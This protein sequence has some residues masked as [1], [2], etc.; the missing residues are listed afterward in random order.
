[1]SGKRLTVLAAIVVALSLSVTV[2]CPVASIAKPAAAK[3]AVKAPAKAPTKAPIDVMATAGPTAVVAVVNG[4]K[5]TKKQLTDL[6]WGNQAHQALD[7]FIIT[8][9]LIAQKAK[10]AG[11]SVTDKE[12][13]AK[14]KDIEKNNLGG[15]KTVDQALSEVGISKAAW[16]E[17]QVRPQILV[18][19]IIEKELKVTD[20]EIAEY[21]HAR[22]IL[23]STQGGAAG[24]DQTKKEADAKTKLEG[25][26]ADIKAGKTDFAAAADEFTGDP[27]NTDPETQKKKGGMLPWFKKGRMMKEFED[28]AF[29]LKPGEMSEPVKTYYG[30]HVIKL[31]KLGKDADP[32]EKL[33][34]K[35][36]V[37][38]EKKAQAQSEF[39]R[40]L[41][42]GASIVDNL[43]VKPKP[44]MAQPP[45]PAPAARPAPAGRPAPAARPAPAP[46][47]APK[48]EAPP[49]PP[50]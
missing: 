17:T 3:A 23:I 44:I 49:T 45:A 46:A 1:M 26:I 9:T 50:K 30:W 39:Q 7:R 32:A 37:L 34:I 22:H 27:S 18:E 38:D 47:P 8:N 36:Q 13:Q 24:E 41:R 2:V 10:K 43:V 4:Q 14:I 33:E 5:V 25:I 40:N 48:P 16:I 6:L 11:V 19:K 15:T 31:E 35:K 12:V 42:T 20:A 29:K 28:A 21:V